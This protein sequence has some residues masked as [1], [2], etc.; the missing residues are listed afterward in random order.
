MKENREE[1]K[2]SLTASNLFHVKQEQEGNQIKNKIPM[3][4]PVEVQPKKQVYKKL[5]GDMKFNFVNE[6]VLNGHLDNILLDNEGKHSEEWKVLVEA[7][8]AAKEVFSDKE[9]LNSDEGVLKLMALSEA[10]NRYYETHIKKSGK[11]ADMRK[12][13]VRAI[14]NMLSNGFA[15]AAGIGADEELVPVERLKDR[16]AG[17]SENVK[18][19]SEYYVAFSKK[20]GEDK[21]GSVVEKLNRR[22]NVLKSCEEDIRIYRQT[23]E[24]DQKSN[25]EI[26]HVIKEYD[27]IRSQIFF[28]K[29]LKKIQVYIFKKPII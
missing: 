24:V 25:P 27:H 12:I 1:L 17:A 16:E 20:I 10:C 28:L 22:W 13:H 26:W 2:R 11:K 14:R 23:H 21:I 4:G 3:F 19:L 5:T 7:V 8:T 15:G 18:R 9:R 29:K 6:A